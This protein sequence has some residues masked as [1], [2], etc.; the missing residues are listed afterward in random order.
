MTNPTLKITSFVDDLEKLYPSETAR[1]RLVEMEIKELYGGQSLLVLQDAAADIDHV[2][3]AVYRRSKECLGETL[4]R[5][6][7]A[8]TC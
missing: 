8:R 3:K 7:R 4:Q 5:T 1:R 6:S 2:A